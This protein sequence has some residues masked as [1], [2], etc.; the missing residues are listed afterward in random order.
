MRKPVTHRS[1]SSAQL[2]GNSLLEPFPPRAQRAVCPV[3]LNVSFH[4]GSGYS[5][6]DQ[7]SSIPFN[8]VSFTRSRLPALPARS[9]LPSVYSTCRERQRG[10]I[11]VFVSVC[12]QKKHWSGVCEGKNFSFSPPS[13]VVMK[14][15][16]LQEI[17]F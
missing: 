12:G 13:C 15:S 5:S 11:S 10:S 3:R 6:P 7:F 1:F 16:C 8:P 2:E 17:Y 14:A 4:F 9:Y